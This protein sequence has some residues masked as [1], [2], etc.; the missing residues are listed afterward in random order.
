MD[1]DK[2]FEITVFDPLIFNNGSF[3]ILVDDNT[4]QDKITTIIKSLKW[5]YGVI[6]TNE[7]KMIDYYSKKQDVFEMKN[8]F[9]RYS[10]LLKKRCFGTH[11][12]L[13]VD[14]YDYSKSHILEFEKHK[15]T[16]MTY[17]VV[18][19]TLTDFKDCYFDYYIITTLL[20]LQGIKDIYSKLNMEI[21]YQDFIG[22]LKELLSEGDYLVIHSKTMNILY[23]TTK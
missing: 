14:C 23:L 12:Y 17:I 11:M 20:E 3:F 1:Q 21:D 8:I 7:D 5:N 13:L 2:E 22:I 10:N 4:V 19:P 9:K 16:E 15:T 18:N 6:L